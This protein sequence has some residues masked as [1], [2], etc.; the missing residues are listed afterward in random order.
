MA[1]SQK[2]YLGDKVIY[3]Q[4]LGDNPTLVEKLTE[5]PPPDP[6]ETNLVLFLDAG[7]D[8]SYPPPYTGSTWTDLSNSN[9][10]VT[11]N[12]AVSYTGSDGGNLI[13]DQTAG[14]R[15]TLAT[16]I[17]PSSAFTLTTWLNVKSTPG[18]IIGDDGN[19]QPANEKINFLANGN[20]LIRTIEGDSAINFNFGYETGSM[21]GEWHQITV[22]RDTNNVFYA[23]VD[24]NPYVTGSTLSGT[25]RFKI[26]GDNA[27]QGQ[28]IDA[29][30]SNMLFYDASLTQDEVNQNYKA[31]RKRYI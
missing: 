26:I 5:S 25:P 9:N 14:G 13:F 30:Y 10:S 23:C 22:M 6:I 3:R 1:E 17:Q 19:G 4:Y 16:S 28:H 7:D 12:A 8:L 18:C 27:N 11:L 31:F 15:G 20:I 24:D 2:Y 21:N 29:S